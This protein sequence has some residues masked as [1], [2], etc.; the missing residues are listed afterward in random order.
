MSSDFP[1]V[2]VPALYVWSDGDPAIGR[3]GAE[4]TADHVTGPYR[5][6]VLEG[7]DH[8]I[9]E[10]AA[11]RVNELLLSHVAASRL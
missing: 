2:T 6:V 8:W 5:F 11:D 10:H 1:D 3:A 4:A 9:P 7:V